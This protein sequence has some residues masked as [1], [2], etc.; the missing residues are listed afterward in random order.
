MP[1]GELF[2]GLESYGKPDY[3]Y[4][5]REAAGVYWDPALRGFK[6]TALKDWTPSQW[7][8]HI[9]DIVRLGLGI[10]LRLSDKALW[11]NFPEPEK[12][13]IIT[14]HKPQKW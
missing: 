13:A 8:S 9:V 7:Y 3:Q 2:V 1:T 14:T 12:R 10:E 5:Y 4:V 6:S 11:R